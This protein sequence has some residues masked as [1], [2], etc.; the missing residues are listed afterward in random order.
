MNGWLLA[1]LRA[2][3]DA[4]QRL[5]ARPLGGLLSLLAIAIALALPAGG[6]TLLDNLRTLA[7]GLA[8]THEISVFLAATGK[9]ADVDALTRQARAAG[10]AAVRFIDKQTAL[11]QLQAQAGMSGLLDGLKDNPLPDALILTPADTSPAAIE[12]LAS[13]AAN[14]PRVEQVRSDALWARRFEAALRVGE[15]ALGVLGALLGAAL[16]AVTFNTIRL[17]ILGRAAEIEVARLIGATPA[18]IRRPFLWFGSVQGLI[19]GGLAVGIVDG[20]LRL[21][22]PAVTDLVTLIGGDFRLH[23]PGATLATA[24]VVAGTLLGW[25]GARLSARGLQP[26]RQ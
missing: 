16:V 24:T 6:L 8:Q 11:D 23:G 18:F 22:A 3:A 21:L 4:L 12:A 26:D 15:V 19:G 9:P 17:Q 10:A 25:L 2:L 20:G 13:A 5:F 14:W 7:G 1:H